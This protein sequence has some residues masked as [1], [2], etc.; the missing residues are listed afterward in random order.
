MKLE[1]KNNKLQNPQYSFPASYKM[2]KM[3][4]LSKL[5]FQRESIYKNNNYSGFTYHES[6]TTLRALYV[7][8]LFDLSSN[9]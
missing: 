3:D 7:G 1:K 2:N 4:K 6:G 8:I 9:S 5:W